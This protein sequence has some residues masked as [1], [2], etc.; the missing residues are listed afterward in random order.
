MCNTIL[1][2]VPSPKF[3]SFDDKFRHFRCLYTMGGCSTNRPRGVGKK[4]REGFILGSKRGFP[5]SRLSLSGYADPA[6]E[7]GGART[8]PLRDPP[9]SHAPRHRNRHPQQ[10]KHGVLH[11]R[12]PSRCSFSRPEAR[13]EAR[14]RAP[15]GPVF[16]A[17]LWAPRRDAVARSLACVVAAAAV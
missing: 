5:A 10:P 11:V 14:P 1:I 17:A 2:S 13:G 12:G 8:I 6:E 3:P 15:H 7:G 4:K 16:I 9:P